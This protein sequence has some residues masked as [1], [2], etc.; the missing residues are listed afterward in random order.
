[1][2]ETGLE[3]VVVFHPHGAIVPGVY[4]PQGTQT[5]TPPSG[6]FWDTARGMLAPALGKDREQG[7]AVMNRLSDM[8]WVVQTLPGVDG[9]ATLRGITCLD[10][11]DEIARLEAIAVARRGDSAVLEINR[12]VWLVIPQDVADLVD[13][14][15]WTRSRRYLLEEAVLAGEPRL[16]SLLA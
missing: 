12:E 4:P 10:F 14:A 13:P 7:V 16:A 15:R 8:E 6:W 9:M 3:P 5:E 2:D 11:A 1:M